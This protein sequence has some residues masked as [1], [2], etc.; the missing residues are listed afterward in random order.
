[1]KAAIAAVD[2]ME[3]EVDLNTLN[4]KWLR[5]EKLNS[6][7]LELTLDD[8]IEREMDAQEKDREVFN[9]FVCNREQ[10]AP[11]LALLF[12]SLIYPSHTRKSNVISDMVRR[13]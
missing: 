7:I 10:L 5:I 13:T 8:E 9:V 4:D 12:L 1:M 3:V 2:K 6:E 11:A